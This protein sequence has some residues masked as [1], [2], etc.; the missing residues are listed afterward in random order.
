[1]LTEWLKSGRKKLRRVVVVNLVLHLP[2]VDLD[3][4]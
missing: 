1:M 2:S 4:L 3:L